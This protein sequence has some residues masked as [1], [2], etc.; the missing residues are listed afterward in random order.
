[1]ETIRNARDSRVLDE[2]EL[3][4]E[5]LARIQKLGPEYFNTFKQNV[6]QT[7]GILEEEKKEESFADREINEEINDYVVKLVSEPDAEPL[8]FL[9]E[10]QS[11]STKNRTVKV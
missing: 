3:F 8:E 7:Y 5:S 1:M 9:L 10:D 2:K 11:D 4:L 6:I